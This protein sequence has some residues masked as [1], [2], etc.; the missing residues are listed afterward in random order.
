MSGRANDTLARDPRWQRFISRDYVCPCCGQPSTGLYD[1]GFDHPDPWPYGSREDSG[2]D[3][4]IVGTNGLG[5][6]LCIFKGG[7]Y[8]RCILPLPIR[9]SDEVFAFGPWASVTQENFDRYARFGDPGDFSGCFGWMVNDLPGIDMA[10]WLPCNVEITENRRARPSLF[11]HAG[12]HP[13][14]DMQRDGITFDQL[15]DIYAA[16]GQDHRPHLADA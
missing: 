5:R 11:V 1:L 10:G 3:V 4:L 9:G 15:L 7:S 13:L 2:E 8:I 16:A 12:A 14:A 6:D